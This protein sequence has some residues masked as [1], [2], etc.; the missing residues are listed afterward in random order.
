MGV[1]SL[2]GT[3]WALIVVS[4]VVMATAA[5][6]LLLGHRLASE[7]AERRATQRVLDLFTDVARDYGFWLLGPEGRIRRWSRGAERIHG[8]DS[9]QVLGRHCANLYSEPDRTA[10]VPQRVLELAARQ[11]R[12]EFRG[13]RV[14]QDGRSVAVD[15]V[16]QALRDT[17]GNLTGFCEVEHDVTGQRQVE[18]TLRQTRSSL[19]Q[20]HKLEAIGRL[21]GGVAHDFNNVIQ[22]I[23]NCVRVLQRRLA[24]QPQQLQFLDMIERNADRAAGL[25]QHLLG[26]AR[27]EP[28]ESGVT[29]VH[30]VIEDA[31]QLLHQTLNENIVLEQQLR[32]QFPWTSIDRTQLEAA[33]LN[34]AANARDAM[35]GGGTL[36]IETS[37]V[38][39]ES[40]SGSAE[41]AD[42]YIT[43]A[44][45][46]SGARI[47]GAQSAMRP[48]ASLQQV[49]QLIEEAGGRLSLE[50]R[51][52]SG[53]TVVMLWLP[54]VRVPSA[55]ASPRGVDSV[56]ERTD[57]GPTPLH[58]T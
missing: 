38:G 20:A 42:P 4:A 58:V 39:V 8:Y 52:E 14:R 30:A 53:G 32:S 19:M 31:L 15:S 9:D 33:L 36:A 44:V 43:I 37:D 29:N 46:D 55:A 11:G 56:H 10:N 57:A 17:S 22:V 3:S 24:D 27:S 41:G 50:S 25:S 7:R 5:G 2:S 34:L 26:F 35:Q 18:Q 47:P 48:D 28:Q 40:S 1:S 16:L 51:P 54:C 6:C 49:R 23:K 13:E 12:H 21:S 45:S